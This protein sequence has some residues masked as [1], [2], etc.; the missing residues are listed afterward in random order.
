MA[1]DDD[2]RFVHLYA[3]PCLSLSDGLIKKGNPPATWRN[4]IT[5]LI[6]VGQPVLARMYVAN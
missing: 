1:V 6:D 5:H 2:D 3:A 4:R